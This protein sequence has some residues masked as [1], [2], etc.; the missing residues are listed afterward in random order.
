MSS[1]FIFKSEQVYTQNHYMDGV[2][3]NVRMHPSVISNQAGVDKL[4]DLTSSYFENGGM[5]VQYNIVDTKTL[6]DAQKHPEDYKDLVVRI[7]GY[8]AYFVDMGEGGLCLGCEAC[9]YPVCP[10]GK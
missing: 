1:P 10:F 7:A 5:E 8:S 6:R 3:L 4:I 2:A 9:H